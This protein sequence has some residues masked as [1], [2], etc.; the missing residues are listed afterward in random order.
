MMYEEANFPA[1]GRQMVVTTIWSYPRN[2]RD[3]IYRKNKKRESLLSLVTNRVR[4]VHHVVVKPFFFHCKKKTNTHTHT[5]THTQSH[6]AITN[7]SR[8]NQ[9]LKK[10]CLPSIQY[11]K[12]HSRMIMFNTIQQQQ[13]RCFS[14]HK[15]L[16]AKT[17][18]D[19]PHPN[20][21]PYEMARRVRVAIAKNQGRDLRAEEDTKRPLVHFPHHY[22]SLFVPSVLKPTKQVVFHVPMEITK[23]EI[24]D[25]LTNYYGLNVE[26]VNTLILRTRSKPYRKLV[27]GM[28]Q[29]AKKAKYFKKA[30]VFLKEAVDLGLDDN[31]KRTIEQFYDRRKFKEYQKEATKE[32]MRDVQ[33]KQEE[34]LRK[35]EEQEK[36][37]P[38]TPQIEAK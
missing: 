28:V 4:E 12:M 20:P 9:Q 6:I 14:V 17:S 24:Q 26:K 38:E 2:I 35:Q 18:G 11:G 22:M 1:I 10:L 33:Q 36:G 5:H 8:M 34:F 30:I 3:W 13:L 7:K 29:H 37:V 21:K 31:V 27:R 25:I 16:F 32:K 15:S 23:P 19:N